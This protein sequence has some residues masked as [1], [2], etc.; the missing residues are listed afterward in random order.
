MILCDSL[1]FVSYIILQQVQRPQK[2]PHKQRDL[3]L[4]AFSAI[5]FFLNLRT[6]LITF[7]IIIV[8][9]FMP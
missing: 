9:I 3:G 6:R 5:F 1:I 4:E 8:K 2:A 7:E